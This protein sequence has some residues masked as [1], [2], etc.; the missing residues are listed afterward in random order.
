MSLV[1]V[2]AVGAFDAVGSVL[3][4][5]LM[6]GPPATAYLLTDRLP[7]M[8]GLSAA[9]G[10][11]CALAGYWSANLFDTSIAGA[12][13]TAVGVAFALAFALAPERG[14]V[15]VAQRKRR[16][17]RTFAEKMLTVHLLHHEDT[18]EEARECR[19][20][21][22]QDH[23]RWSPDFARLAVEAA[24]RDGYILRDADRLWLTSSGRTWAKASMVD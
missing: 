13:A 23:L 4:V 24:E 9:V 14:L 12:M 16:Q 6:I 15:A 5:A 20:P 2:T 17:R 10:L 18:P 19:V 22:L 3:V 21:H 11:A 7:V 1:S 8:L